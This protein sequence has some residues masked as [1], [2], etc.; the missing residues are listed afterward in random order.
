LSSP[1]R[2]ALLVTHVFPP[3]VAGGA[4]R[5]GQF[6]RILPDYGWD[7][8]V[9]TGRHQA[10]ALD[11]AALDE[12]ARR[13]RIVQAWSPATRL[14]K[15]GQPVP[16]YGL[17]G[18][19]RRVV[20]TAATSVVFP[21]REVFWVPGAIE[22]GRRALTEQPHDL[23]I[24]TYG[25]GSNLIVGRALASAFKLPLVVDFRDLW[26]T[27]PMKNAFPTR[28]HRAAARRLEH[29]VV[30]KASRLLAVAPAMA[31]DLAATHGLANE[32]AIA[33]TN[34]FDPNDAARVRDER[35]S[36]ARPFRL[37][38]TGT[39]HV[40]YN[41]MPLW[42]AVRT[43]LDRG[44]I[45]PDTFRIE[46]VGN[47]SASDVKRQG[48][49]DIVE[50][51]PFVPHEQVFAAF[52]RADALLVVETPGYYAR[53]GYAAK[54]FDYVLSGK[55]IVGLV[56]AGGNTDSLLRQ[57][58]V[59]YCVDPSDERGLVDVLRSVLRLK[60]AQP[61]PMD[62]DKPPLSDFNRYHL[63]GKLAAVLDDVV[64]SEPRGRW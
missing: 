7:V 45:T 33:I 14:V 29:S 52:A 3:L 58:G 53:Y 2:R 36:G 64:A 20:R 25:P 61:K 47:L 48:L 19:A 54:V 8:T 39:V 13:V 9:L 38:Y 21:D 11:A 57:A 18:A 30:H 55:P 63:V 40:H 37:M 49:A 6:A 23:V 62:P 31:Q 60:G 16:K 15:R 44:E 22:A 28:L 42:N 50:I 4:P 5:M 12:I 32:H 17:L 41:L 26:S 46:F 51:S 1:R 24:A 27:L 34:G 59:G 35:P 56:E 10:A 43:L